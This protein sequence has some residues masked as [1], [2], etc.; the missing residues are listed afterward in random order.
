MR[1]LF[2]GD[3]HNHSYIFEDIKKLDDKYR[4]D[5]IIFTGDYVDDWITD[6]HQSLET[7]DSII[8]LTEDK[9][10]LIIVN[11]IFMKALFLVHKNNW[12]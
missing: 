12:R 5:R 6:N 3:V 11:K 8:N 7:L 4:F 9:L 1:A 2:V 10:Y